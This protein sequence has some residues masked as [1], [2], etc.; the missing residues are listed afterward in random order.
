MADTQPIPPFPLVGDL[1]ATPDYEL[2]RLPDRPWVA[3]IANPYSG[4]RGNRK[5]VQRLAAALA[6]HEL[7]SV[8]TWNPTQ[9]KSLLNHAQL[10]RYCCCI[11]VAGGDGTIAAVCNETPPGPARA[12]PLAALPLGNENLIAKH[13]RYRKPQALADA[14]VRGWHQKIDLGFVTPG[15]PPGAQAPGASKDPDPNPG[16]SSGP[17]ASAPW[18]LA[19]E[20]PGAPGA[21]GARAFTLMLSAGLDAQVVHNVAQW[22]TRGSKLKRVRHASYILPS[23][24]AIAAYRYPLLTLTTDDGRSFQGCHAF[25]FNIPRYALNLPFA[26]EALPSDGLLDFVVLQKP[27]LRRAVAYLWAVK[28]RRHLYRP[29][30]FHGRA[31]AITLTSDQPVPLQTDG[32]PAGFTPATA[33][34]TPHAVEMLLI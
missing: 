19:P 29:D 27:G 13:F 30:V 2:R 18:A 20:A 1:N 23:L 34:V 5:E 4:R 15:I 32:D 26:P 24:K 25:I 16:A 17:G 21:P 11:V 3:I 10:P 6:Q 22:R 7:I 28:R 33:T 14:I 9:R 31:R 12:I 8:T